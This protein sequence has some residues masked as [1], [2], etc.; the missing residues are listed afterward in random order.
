[1]KTR[2]LTIA[3]ALL[4]VGVALAT[5]NSAAGA[6]TTAPPASASSASPAN[7]SARSRDHSTLAAVDKAMADH[8]ASNFGQAD[9]R[10]RDA[11]ERC[12]A[13]RCSPSVKASALLALGVVM[14]SGLRKPDDAKAAF[15]Q[16]LVLDPAAAL[17]PHADAQ[18]QQLFAEVREQQNPPPPPPEEPV[19]AASTSAAPLPTEVPIAPLQSLGE[20][21]WKNGVGLIR[22][23]EAPP[24]PS[25][26]QSW[27]APIAL[28]APGSLR[29]DQLELQLR[30]GSITYNPINDGKTDAGG[31]TDLSGILLELSVRPEWRAATSPV[32]IWLN[33]R[34][35]LMPRKSGTLQ[36]PNRGAQPMD[37]HMT[38]LR[39][40]GDLGLDAVP[41]PFVGLGPF[42]GYRGDLFGLNVDDTDAVSKASTGDTGFDAFDHGL[43][44]GGHVRLRTLDRVDR[45]AVL[46][47]DA[48]WFH[49]RGRIL[50]GVYQRFEVGVRPGADFALGLWYERRSSASGYASIKEFEDP[51]DVLSKTMAVESMYGVGFGG[52]FSIAEEPAAGVPSAIL[53]AGRRGK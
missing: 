4:P 33:V 31:A 52:V 6:P 8:Q 27:G 46:Y 29:F 1:M 39:F 50:T 40:G 45:P 38:N 49:R 20:A 2:D 9:R 24:P 37:V 44:Y 15:A 25:A 12:G 47:G 30:A 32:A 28:R 36:L 10:L 26:D 51:A 22:N 42:I 23:G 43:E 53:G 11:L 3:L 14:A 21:S 48:A 17:P 34:V 16:A 18:A 35:G 13:E 5:A 41:M 19:P 7:A